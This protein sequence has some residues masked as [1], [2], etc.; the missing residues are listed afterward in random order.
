MRTLPLLLA[1]LSTPVLAAPE[2]IRFDP[3]APFNPGNDT[4]HLNDLDPNAPDI[5]LELYVVNVGSGA[6]GGYLIPQI[7]GGP[8]GPVIESNVGAQLTNGPSGDYRFGNNYDE[9]PAG[10]EISNETPGPWGIAYGHLFDFG[11]NSGYPLEILLFGSYPLSPDCQ[12]CD[13]V[14]RVEDRLV[15]T[16]PG[17]KYIATRWEDGGSTYYGWIVLRVDL[18]GYPD[19]CVVND[20][21]ECDPNDFAHLTG[22]R[23]RYI[24][25]AYETEPD[26][27]VLA[28]GGLCR[29]DMNFDAR[30]DFFDISEFLVH[31]NATDLAADFTGEGNLDFFDV[32][33]F[34][35]EYN[36]GCE[37]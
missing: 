2:V 16:A 34:I 14:S 21:F 10:S 33:A 26:T 31:Y 27:P 36:A 25:A 32:A 35:T 13:Y 19:S 18:F 1:A 8:S 6:N 12:L 7:L 20:P 4:I 24:A 22:Y 17:M 29:A 23:I 15:S 9:L 30:F 11:A 5:R 3:N 28:G 37:F